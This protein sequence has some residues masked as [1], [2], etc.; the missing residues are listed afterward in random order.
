MANRMETRATLENLSFEMIE[1]LSW[2]FNICTDEEGNDIDH[3]I[4]TAD[5]VSRLFDSSQNDPTIEYCVRNLGAK[6]VNIINPEIE[7][8]K[9]LSSLEL[10]FTSAWSFPEGLIKRLFEKLSSFDQKLVIKGYFHDETY[11]PTGVFFYSQK[12]KEVTVVYN[13]SLDE[14]RMWD[15]D[16]YREKIFD[17]LEEKILELETRSKSS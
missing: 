5:I 4:H 2:F 9:D 17:S 1:W 3:E 16:F 11:S 8:D 15:D 12:L 10:D 13:E 6:W 14:D 7:I